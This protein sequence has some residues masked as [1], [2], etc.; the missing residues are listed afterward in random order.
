ME[1]LEGGGKFT[2]EI[3]KPDGSYTVIFQKTEGDIENRFDILRL[4]LKK[5]YNKINFN[6]L[7]SGVKLEK[8]FNE[9]I[10]NEINSVKKEKMNNPRKTKELKQYLDIIKRRYPVEYE[11]YNV[12]I[13]NKVIAKI[14]RTKS[15]LKKNK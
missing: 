6:D 11:A 15:L 3:N 13:K 10:A 2:R 4:K 14:R 5:E 9:I 12:K 8:V 7:Y 1:E